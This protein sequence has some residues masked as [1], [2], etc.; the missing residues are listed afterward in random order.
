M[1]IRSLLSKTKN[2]IALLF[3]L[4]LI[5]LGMFFGLV[6]VGNKQS[7]PYHQS[8][9][10]EYSPDIDRAMNLVMDLPGGA[11]FLQPANLKHVYGV[12]LSHHIPTT[13]PRLVEFYARLKRI[14]S[15]KNFIVIGPDHTDSGKSQVT[16]SNA[17]FFT[18]YGEVEPIDGL[19]LS[20]QNAKLANIE[21]SPFGPEHSVGSQILVIGKIFPEARVT[22][23][24]IR[25]D[26]TSDH[27]RALG[28]ILAAH[29]DDETVLV[30]SIDFSHYLSTDQAIPIDRVSGEVM[31]NLDLGSLSLVEA[32]SPRSVESFMQAMIMKGASDTSDFVVLNTDDFMQNSDN[33]T[34]YVF[35]Y[36]GIK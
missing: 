6:P 1:K 17:N 7:I 12:V 34:G 24:I 30:A 16:V 26:T 19:A 35:G 9:W 28:K 3:L 23:I 32:D 21:E 15:V 20:L 5:I 33:T 31:R 10:N 29:L 4:A 27:A 36:W 25:S 18:A 8:R 22:P 13:I 11:E 2:K 14:Q